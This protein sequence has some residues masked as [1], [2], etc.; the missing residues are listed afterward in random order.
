MLRLLLSRFEAKHER[1]ESLA[2]ETNIP[3][4]FSAAVACR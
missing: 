4:S 1:H 2:D 3:G